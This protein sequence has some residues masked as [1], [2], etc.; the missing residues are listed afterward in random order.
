MLRDAI[1]NKRCI[2]VCGGGGVG[3]TTIAASIAISAA[4]TRKR[5]LVVTIDPA[6]RLLEAFGF[7]NAF[8]QEGG[9][10]LALSPEIKSE[11]GLG[12][13]ANLSIAVLNPK[14]VLNQILEQALTPE[15]GEKL[16]RTVL[17]S[18]ISQMIYGLQEYT[19]Y[20]WVTRMIQNNEFDL[21]V[22]DTP[23]A[24]HAKDFFGAPDK[25]KRL[26]E[27]RVF[28]IFL[29]KKTW[30]GSISF[31][32]MEKLLG[33]TVFG[34]SKIFFE[35]FTTL[36]ARILERC[37]LLAKF[38]KNEEV[39]VI[40]VSTLESSAQ[41]ELDGLMS[42]LLSRQISVGTVILNQVEP[43]K[44][45]PAPVAQAA[46]LPESLQ[47]KILKLRHYQMS[48]M[49]EAKKRLAA[50]QARYPKVELIPVS[51]N[52]SQNGFEILKVNAEQLR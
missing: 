36:R 52:Y 15:Q 14:Y 21:I 11:F 32:W 43:L 17:F 26:M 30:F 47:E 48:R 12:P 10:P 33:H 51:M 22:L 28:Q 18:E 40:A 2:M 42:F 31:A 19:A 41:V 3:K 13:E 29:P 45:K 5:V 37:D 1:A 46:L 38:F 4:K 27:S 35:V 24:V 6:K 16:K 44:S 25:I 8:L 23:P 7:A 49:D 9:E 50:T 34:E 20:E 39:A